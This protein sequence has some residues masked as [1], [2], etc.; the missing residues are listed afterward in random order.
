[1]KVVLFVLFSFMLI[2]GKIFCQGNYDI[3]ISNSGSDKNP[4][5]S[6]Q[7]P[8]QTITGADSIYKRL[9]KANG[10]VSIGLKSGDVFSEDCI[11]SYPMQLNTYYNSTGKNDFALLNG[12]DKF[13]SGWMKLRG[14]LNTY[15]QPIN[16]SGSM[17]QPIGNYSYIY[18]IEID[19]ELEKTAPITARKLLLLAPSIEALD[20]IPGTFYEPVTTNNPVTLYLHTSNSSTPNSNSRY[21]YEVTTRFSSIYDYNSVKNR[22]ENLWVRGYGSG[23]GLIASAD[24]TYCDHVIFGPGA[25]IHHMVAKGGTINNCLFLPASNN[26]N[27]FAF[28]FY[29]T[30]GSGKHNFISNSMFLDIPYPLYSHTNNGN[31][32]SLQLD[33]VIAFAN[34][35]PG[36]YFMNISNNDSVMLNNVYVDKYNTDYGNN[37][38]L[39]NSISNCYFKDA[40]IAI[41]YSPSPVQSF[42]TNTFIKA[43][44]TGILMTSNNSVQIINSIIHMYSPAAV[45]TGV[46]FIRNQGYNSNPI[47]ASGNIFINDANTRQPVIMATANTDS[48]IATSYD[49]WNNN[50]Y[51]VLRNNKLNWLVTNKTTNKGSTLVTTFSEWQR[52]SGQDK[53]S[54]YFDLSNDPR[55]LK[56]I[57]IDPDNGDYELANT[58]E[59]VQIKA[60]QAG[61]TNPITCF[62]QE[63]TYEHAAS[64][65]MNYTPMLINSCRNPCL[66]SDVRVNYKFDPVEL[67]HEQI[68]LQWT[69][70]EQQNIDHFEVERSVNDT[71]FTSIYSSPVTTDSTYL[72]VDHDIQVNVPYVYR[73]AVVA[74][75]GNICYSATD[76]IKVV[77]AKHKMVIYPNPSTG[78][79]MV[80][81]NGYSGWA[82]FVITNATGQTVLTSG[83][84]LQNGTAQ[85]FDLTNRSKGIYFLKLSTIDGLYVERFVID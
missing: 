13:D 79:I 18:V 28:V 42:I 37:D 51:I 8:R 47:T 36:V 52:Q 9:Y 34:N 80:S 64:M 82:Y 66:F 23:A 6:P 19:K 71:S 3:Y 26:I 10:K 39:Y 61:M 85:T 14:T 20:T 29:N 70:A 57:F 15:S 40:A 49:K 83:D 31:F 11:A 12:S 59:A 62:L 45:N 78:K 48:G 5:T 25:A 58:P 17:S 24:S 68:Q 81:M 16:Y 75:N 73:L 63:P 50:V 69:V 21:R 72:F 77:S 1:M 35:S 60:L 30:N 56:A 33:S 7:L 32:R 84:Y 76:T 55:G 41:R 67:N 65:I 38:A 53:N 27:Q 44:S 4:G 54:L 74:K 22:F 46:N 2:P 43:F